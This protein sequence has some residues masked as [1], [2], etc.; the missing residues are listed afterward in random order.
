MLIV[1][2]TEYSH[3]FIQ[4]GSGE[5]GICKKIRNLCIASG[6]QVPPVIDVFELFG[7]EQLDTVS[8]F[9]N[10][11]QQLEALGHG[12]LDEC[13]ASIRSHVLEQLQKKMPEK[14]LLLALSWPWQVIA[15]FRSDVRRLGPLVSKCYTPLDGF[16]LDSSFPNKCDLLV[17]EC[18]YA[19]LVGIRCGIPPWKMLYL[20]HYYPKEADSLFSLSEDIVKQKQCAYI[21]K[22]ADRMGK[23][24]PSMEKAVLVGCVSRL[25]Q[26]KNIEDAIEA[27]EETHRHC[28]TALFVLKSGPASSVMGDEPYQTWLRQLLEK[29]SSKPW[30]FWDQEISSFPQVLETF[31]LF[32]CCMLL[33]GVEGAS[34]VA[35]EMAGLGRP[36]LMLKE[37]TNPCLFE[38]GFTLI[39][40]SGIQER[41]F[42]LGV[43]YR[44][45][46]KHLLVDRLLE[47]VN[48]EDKRGERSA[49]ARAMA[50]ERFSQE[51]ALARL[52][53]MREAAFSYYRECPLQDHYKR[54]LEEQLAKDLSLYR[55]KEP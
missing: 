15:L 6:M 28:P 36:C 47:L 45:P 22:L 9:Y 38:G 49:Q 5:I 46:D 44:R 18:L 24:M 39:P 42:P 11:N 34:N 40:D 13:D 1:G 31:R 7:K 23:K 4:E 29:V 8:K 51:Q 54:V 27:F 3:R 50:V 37:N 12:P 10:L 33:S 53:L 48:S 25:K 14:G 26:G 2:H 35:V 20:P 43:T 30:F 41:G 16:S 19:N 52:P 55:I 32:D 21:K 17:T